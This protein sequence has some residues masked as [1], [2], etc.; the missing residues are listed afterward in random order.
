MYMLTS[1]VEVHSKQL[2]S[3]VNFLDPENLLEISVASDKS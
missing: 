1:K 3:Q 2:I